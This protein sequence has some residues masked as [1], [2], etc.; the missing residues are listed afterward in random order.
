MAAGSEVR[1]HP[2]ALKSGFATSAAARF[3]ELIGKERRLEDVTRAMRGYVQE[4][5]PPVVG[6]MQVTCSDEAERECIEDFQRNFVRY[7]LPSLKFSSK[8]SFQ[9]ATLGGRYEWGSVRIAEDHYAMAR[10]ADAWKLLLVKV[11]AHVSVEEVDGVPRYGKMERYHTES[12]FCGALH[13]LLEG[14]VLP[15]ADDLRESFS[16]EDIDRISELAD[17]AQ[18]DV[19]LRSLLAAVTSARLQARRA[20]IDIQ[21]Y[22]PVSPTLYLVVPCVTLNRRQHDSEIPVGIYTCDRREGVAHDEYCGLEDIPSEYR[23]ERD[24]G[25]LVVTDDGYDKPRLARD[26][27]SLVIDEWRRGKRDVGEWHPRLDELLRV[28]E[29][30]RPHH[31]EHTMAKAAL[32]TLLVAALEL[33]PIPAAV[34]LFGAGLVNVHHAAKAHRLARSSAEDETARRM[35]REVE[36]RIDELSQ[37]QARHLVE[38]LLQEYGR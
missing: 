25:Q 36:G 13:A 6:A 11:N 8:A 12:V 9:V 23:V 28:T 27:R 14:G 32:K 22:E 3:Y 33:A 29:A 7:L 38:L 31:G 35:L 21:D 1:F 16:I 20:V 17:P 19:E 15:F 34:V 26:H 30:E 37:E 5:R 24:R 18:V 4:L 10:G 2:S